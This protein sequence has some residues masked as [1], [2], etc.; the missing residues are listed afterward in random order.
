VT[1]DAFGRVS[2]F[3][4][5]EN[6]DFVGQFDSL[7]SWSMANDSGNWAVVEYIAHAPP[8][9]GNSV[10]LQNLLLA[11]GDYTIAAAGGTNCV[12]VSP[13]RITNLAGTLSFSTTV[14]PLP[15]S[16][17]LLGTAFAAAGH[18]ARRRKQK[19]GLMLN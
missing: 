3:R 8:L 1:A 2:P 18:W 5:T 9:G 15:A 17:W 4:D 19:R 16:A 12:N 11:A 7:K 13:C 6:I 10:S 14:V